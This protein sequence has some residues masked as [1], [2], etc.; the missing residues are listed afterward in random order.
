[1]EIPEEG[2]EKSI[3]VRDPNEMR[4][5][6]KLYYRYI[7]SLTTPPCTEDVIWTVN[8]QVTQNAASIGSIKELG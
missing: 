7:G 2:E 1:M 6:S 4:P 8:K 3:G 5:D